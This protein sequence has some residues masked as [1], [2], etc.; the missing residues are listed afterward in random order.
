M[1][2]DFEVGMVVE[3]GFEGGDKGVEGMVGMVFVGGEC[4]RDL[5]FG[6]GVGR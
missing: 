3:N 4:G 1:G 6:N 5:V 2:E